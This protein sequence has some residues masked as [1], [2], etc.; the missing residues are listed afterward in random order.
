[1]SGYSVLQ[2]IKPRDFLLR[3]ETC[4]VAGQA[5]LRGH[6]GSGGA[7]VAREHFGGDAAVL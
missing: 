1:M 5:R 6:L 3:G 7:I 4:L 2:S